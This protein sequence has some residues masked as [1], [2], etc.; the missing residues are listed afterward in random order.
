MLVSRS[1]STVS[2]LEKADY[3]DWVKDLKEPLGCRGNLVLFA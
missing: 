1:M 2:I 3:S